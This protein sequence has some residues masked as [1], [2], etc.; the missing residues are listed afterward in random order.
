VLGRRNGVGAPFPNSAAKE[1]ELF[2]QN[3]RGT[4]SFGLA[5]IRDC[6]GRQGWLGKGAPTPF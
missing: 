1:A 4:T 5:M 2:A 6:N 3:I